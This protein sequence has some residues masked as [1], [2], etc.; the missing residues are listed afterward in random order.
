VHLEGGRVLQKEKRSYP[1]F[2]TSPLSW[3]AAQEKF[4]RLADP[5]GDRMLREATVDAVANI[6]QIEISGLAWLLGRFL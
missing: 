4:N 2:V 3:E 6:E 5:H 1:G